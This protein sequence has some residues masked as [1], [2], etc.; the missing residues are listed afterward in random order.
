M[1]IFSYFSVLNPE[2][3]LEISA[4]L[5]FY[6][7][8]FFVLFSFA[9]CHCALSLCWL[10]IIV[11]TSFSG[12]LRVGKGHFKFVNTGNLSVH[13]VYVH[14]SFYIGNKDIIWLAIFPY[15]LWTIILC[16]S[17]KHPLMH[18]TIFRHLVTS[19]CFI[20]ISFFC[21]EEVNWKT[22]LYEQLAH[23]ATPCLFL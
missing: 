17:N 6:F 19:P 16:F 23:T 18:T 13:Y 11:S 8:L 21:V 9:G 12:D 2:W 3:I 10:T 7:F 14:I 5:Y 20:Q 4:T 22:R 15:D 1:Y